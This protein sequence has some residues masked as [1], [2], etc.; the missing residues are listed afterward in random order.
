MIS[1]TLKRSLAV[2]LASLFIIS[3]N[4]LGAYPIASVQ[5][6]GMGGACVARG[7]DTLTPFF[8]PA[9][10]MDVGCRTDLG[11]ITRY[12]EQSMS[13]SNRPS[14][15][16]GLQTGDVPNIDLWDFYG[17]AGWNQHWD[18]GGHW[19]VNIQW[20]NYDHQHTHYDTQL[21]DFSGGTAAF[22]LGT[23]AK[24]NYRAEALTTSVAYEAG[25]FISLGVAANWYFSWLDISG[26]EGLVSDDLTI[27]PERFTNE[28]TDFAM[29]VG[30]TV[31]IVA[32]L[33]EDVRIGF[34]YSPRVSMADFKNYTGFLATGA[35]DIPE[36][37]RLGATTKLCGFLLAMDGEV[38][39]YSRVTSWANDFP[40]SSTDDFAPLFGE[41]DGPGFGWI[42]QWTIRAG[43]ERCWASWL[44]GRLGYRWEESPIPSKGGTNTALNALTLNVVEQYATAGF[45]I[46]PDLMSEISGF[47]EYGFFNK[48]RSNFP[49]I[50][51]APDWVAADLH[52]KS[53]NVKIGVGYGRKY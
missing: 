32:K 10:A 22:P 18:W 48:I 1:W 5:A 39:R 4:C 43:I 19:A 40:G 38:R 45:T 36:T 41:S 28:G 53:Y 23:N 12:T 25:P 42:D 37:Y 33:D 29:G 9:T 51:A 2:S 27:D 24:F 7:L 34:S 15:P 44:I 35:L 17:E 50:G 14:F 52:L 8:N 46:R 30:V 49:A 31:G 3:G 20:N 16:P 21:R 13:L 6:R 11:L 26:L 47:V